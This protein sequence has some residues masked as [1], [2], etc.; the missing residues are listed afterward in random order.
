VPSEAA[1]QIAGAV[2]NGIGRPS[3]VLELGAGTGEVGRQLAI[4]ARGYVGLDLSAP[5]LA[6]FRAKLTSM[7]TPSQALLL[8]ADGDVHW[9]V[10]HGSVAV[11]FA[12]RVAHLL[13]AAHVV[14]EAGRV[15]GKDGRFVVGRIERSGIKQVLR[16]QREAI[17]ADHGVA[18]VR[19]GGRRTQAL[20]EA[21]VT[22][23][24]DVERK[25]AVA[26][27]TVTTTA[28]DVIAGWETMSSMGGEAVAPEVRAEVLSELRRWAG[29][30]LGDLDRPQ[31]SLET[32][33]LEGVRLG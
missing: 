21:F 16:R 30:E 23:G 15:C 4:L 33:T 27:W 3:T 2:L 10:R 19:S 11:V 18:G 12:S 28:E 31:E 20:L 9:P 14:S 13:D 6:V 7:P 24:A 26:T 25:R 22:A 1:D 8:Q 17:L 32:Y 29:A 5:M